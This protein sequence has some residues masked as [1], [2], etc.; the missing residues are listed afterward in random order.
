[1]CVF[2]GSNQGAKPVYREA[3]VR[4]AR[5]LVARGIGIVYG[6]GNVG[7]M[8][9]LADAALQAGGEVIGV[10]PQVPSGKRSGAFGPDGNACGAIDA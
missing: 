4:L 1:M 2:C 3:T 8:G 5:E 9:V 7:L 6:A 10:I